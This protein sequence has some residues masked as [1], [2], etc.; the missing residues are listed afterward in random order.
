M[1]DGEHTIPAKLFLAHIGQLTRFESLKLDFTNCETLG[2]GK[3]ELPVFASTRTLS[4]EF[5]K[6][7]PLLV[8]RAFP[9]VERLTLTSVDSHLHAANDGHRE[10]FE[11]LAAALP[12]SLRS[13]HV[14]ADE[15]GRN[16]FLGATHA[17]CNVPKVGLTG[18]FICFRAFPSFV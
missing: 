17:Y 1:R 13:I 10:F 4:I 3:H 8:L 11:E 15:D 18:S 6:R 14:C 2:S 9:N 16:L 7:F 5:K 12:A